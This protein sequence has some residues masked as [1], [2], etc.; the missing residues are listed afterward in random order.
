VPL[1]R[2]LHNCRSGLKGHLALRTLA[3]VS[4]L[5]CPPVW[6]GQRLRS[7]LLPHNDANNANRSRVAASVDAAHDDRQQR[8]LPVRTQNHSEVY[9]ECHYFTMESTRQVVALSWPLRM[10]PG[11]HRALEGGWRCSVPG[12]APREG[13]CASG[14]GMGRTPSASTHARDSTH[15]GLTCQGAHASPQHGSNRCH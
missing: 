2:S 12:R 3:K 10:I 4:A 6:V 9:P 15:Q 13:P 11:T 5:F 14:P 1:C 7:I 8:I